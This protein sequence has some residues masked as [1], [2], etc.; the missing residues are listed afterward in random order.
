MGRFLIVFMLCANVVYAQDIIVKTDIKLTDTEHE[1]FNTVFC[2]KYKYEENK[3]DS[4]T[5]D[6]FALRMS[7]QEWKDAYNDY[8][9]K[10]D[11][12]AARIRKAQRAKQ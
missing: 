5:E 1:E 3:L 6:S 7:K 12:I 10:Q 8:L 2:D 9:Y 4:E 11:I